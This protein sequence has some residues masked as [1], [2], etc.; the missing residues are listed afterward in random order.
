MSP[1]TCARLST[2]DSLLNSIPDAGEPPTGRAEFG[3]AEAGNWWAVLWRGEP[4]CT[5]LGRA[6][7]AELGRTCAVRGDPPPDPLPWLLP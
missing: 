4:G 2:R 5:G 1:S 7:R 6:G 3:R